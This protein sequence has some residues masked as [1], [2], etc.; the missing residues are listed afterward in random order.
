MD[1]MRDYPD[2]TEPEVTLEHHKRYLMWVE[3]F[4]KSHQA[5]TKVWEIRLK[6]D[7]IRH[8]ML[9]AKQK[10]IRL[11]KHLPE[12]FQMKKRDIFKRK[13]S[14]R[15]DVDWTMILPEVFEG[16]SKKEASERYNFEPL[17]PIPKEAL[18]DDLYKCRKVKVYKTKV[19]KLYKE[20]ESLRYQHYELE[21]EQKE[22][23]NT[24]KYYNEKCKQARE[25]DDWDQ[26][27][28][29]DTHALLNE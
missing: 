10:A 2:P 13:M 8:D 4:R 26:R 27:Q 3:A 9:I 11:R 20:D 19:W 15:E 24:M 14:W 16:P 5:K 28:V 25:H 17:P 23:H 21:H 7:Q 18:T 22:H 29:E 1:R 12:V 6:I